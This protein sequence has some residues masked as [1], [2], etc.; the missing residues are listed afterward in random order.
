M[1]NHFP[2]SVNEVFKYDAVVTPILRLYYIT[3]KDN[4]I[5]NYILVYKTTQQQTR[6]NCNTASLEKVNYHIVSGS[7][8]K[9]T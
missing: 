4:Q 1:Y 5:Y 2:L 9:G 3:I 7:M 6:E 8:E